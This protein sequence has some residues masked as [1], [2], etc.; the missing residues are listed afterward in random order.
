MIDDRGISPMFN[1]SESLGGWPVI[2]EENWDEASWSWQ[3]TVKSF[4]KLGFSM[5][6]ILD[7]SIGV[8]LKESTKRIIDVNYTLY[9][10]IAYH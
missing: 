7:F 8:D 1:I 5:D 9:Y 3:E 6:Y 2:K 4:R 10:Y